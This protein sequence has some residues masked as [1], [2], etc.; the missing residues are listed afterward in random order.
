MDEQK[1]RDFLWGDISPSNGLFNANRFIS[2]SQ[3]DVKVKL[4]GHFTAEQL[5]AIAWW[6]RNAPQPGG[7]P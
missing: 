1:A 4:D 5:D 2:W 7:E 6:M 3:G